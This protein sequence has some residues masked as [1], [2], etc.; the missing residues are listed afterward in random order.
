MSSLKRNLSDDDDDDHYRSESSNNKKRQNSFE[1]SGSHLKRKFTDSAKSSNLSDEEDTPVKSEKA[2][3]E[4]PA[5]TTS[6]FDPLKMLV[7]F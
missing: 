7:C 5:P 6:K 4:A 1:P 2:P 3:K